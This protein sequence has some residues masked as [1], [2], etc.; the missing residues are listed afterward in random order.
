[1]GYVAG[2]G[3][4]QERQ[5]W[6]NSGRE[7]KSTRRSKTYPTK[8]ETVQVKSSGTMVRLDCVTTAL[9]LPYHCPTTARPLPYH[10][11]TTALL[12]EAVTVGGWS[13]GRNLGDWIWI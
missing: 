10:C 12:V 11:P 4:R 5:K 7:I 1:M 8:E 13:G 6:S 9:P 2:H 3:Q